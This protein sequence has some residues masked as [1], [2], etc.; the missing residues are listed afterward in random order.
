PHSTKLQ[1]FYKGPYHSKVKL[2]STVKSISESHYSGARNVINT[3]LEE[4]IYK[5]ALWVEISPTKTI[6]FS[7]ECRILTTELTD[8]NYEKL[9][10]SI[11]NTKF[12]QNCVIAELSKCSQELTVAEFIEFGSFRS[13]HRLQW[14]NL[15]SIL[16]SDS[17]SMDEESVAILITHALLQYGPVTDDPT[18]LLNRWCPE[19]HQQLLE[20]HFLDELMTRIERHLKDCECN[21]QK[22]LILITITIIVMRMFSL[23]NSTRK[24]Q[25]TN[26][27][28]KCRRLGEKWIQA[29]SKHIQNP[30]SLDSD[31]TNTLRDK[32]FI[33]GIACLQTFSIYADTSNSLE[34]SNQDVIFLLNISITVHDNMILTKK[35]TNM[36]VFMRN[37]LRSKERILVTIQ[38]LV[39]ELLEKTSYESLNE[40]CSLHWVIL[41]NKDNMKGLWKKRSKDKYDGWYDGVY[42]SNTISIDCVRGGFFVNELSIGFL[43]DKITSD[44]L[45][46]RVFGQHIFEV[47]PSESE[48]TYITKYGYHANGKTHYEFTFN[49]GNNLDGYLIV[50]ER[51]METNDKFELI[52]PSCFETELPDILVSNYS[53]WWNEK[54]QIV[55]FRSIHFLDPNFLTDKHY[56]LELKNGFIRT[57]NTKNR[58]NLINPSSQF[59]QNLFAMYFKRLDEE[60]YVYMLREGITIFHIH[61]SRLGIAFKYD[62][63]NKIITSREYSDMHIDENQLFGTLTGLESGLL[64]SSIAKVNHENKHYLCR[65]LIV[66]FGQLQSK[67][68]SDNDHQIVT[69]E[70]KSLE[71]SFI[72][73]YFV[74]TLNDRLRILQPTDSPT[75]YLYSAL[76]HALTSHP[77]PDQYTGMTG[78]ERSFQLLYSA[79]CWSDQPFDS[80][81]RNILLQIA[82]IS[83]RVN[84]YP[85]YLTSM[86]KVDWNSNSIP[87]SM[88]HFGYYLL[89]KELSEASEEWSFMYPSST[90]NDDLQKLF[91]SKKYNEKVLAKLYWDYRD[92]YN[93]SARLPEQMEKEIQFS[94]TS[95]DAYQPVWQTSSYSTTYYQ[96]SV[97]DFLYSRGDVNLKDSNKLRCTPLSRWLGY[98]YNVRNT[99]IGLFKIVEEL[100]TFE[101]DKQKDEMERFEMLLDFLHYIS[102]KG[103]RQPFYLQLLKSIL[104]APSLSLGSVPYPPFILYNKIQENSFDDDCVDLD[105]LGSYKR[106]IVLQEIRDCYHNNQHYENEKFSGLEFLNK[107]TNRINMLLD[108]WRKNAK[109]RSFLDNIESQLNSIVLVPFNAIVRVNP[110]EFSL[111][112]FQ[113]HTQI[114]LNLTH[115]TIHE[116]LLESAKQ[117]FLHPYSNY[118]IKP[119]ACIQIKNEQNIFPEEIFPSTNPQVNPLSDIAKHFKEH[120]R[121]SWKKFNLTKEYKREY[122]SVEEINEFLNSFCQESTQLWDEL[123]KS[124][125]NKNELIYKTGLM[126]RIVPTTLISVLWLNDNKSNALFLQ[127]TSEQRIL[128]GG[129]MVNWVVEQQIERTLHLA[130]QEKWEDFDKEISNIPHANWTPSEHIPW[131]ILE[132]EMNIT[133]REIQIEVARHMMQ[134]KVH[135]DNSK[136][137]NVVM[138]MN[139]GEGKTSVILPMLAVSLC[140]STSSLVRIIVLKALFPMNYQSLQ[141]KLGG[142]LNRCVLPFACRRDMNFDDSQVNKIFNRLKQG[143]NNRDVILTSPEDIL[144]FDLLTIDKCRRNEFDAGRAMLSI[145]NWTKIFVRDVLD[146]SDEILHV[147]YQLIYSIGRQQ[148]VDGGA[149]RWR[150]IQDVLKL[151]KKYSA[152]IAQKYN[153]DVFYKASESQSSFPEF[154]LLNHRPFSE[155]CQLIANDW[156]NE[157]HY[158]KIDQ[159]NILSFL[160]SI[161]SSL[162]DLINPFPHDTIQLF[163]IIRGLLSSEVLFASLKKRHRVNFGVNQNS[164]FNR[165]MAV[166]FRAKDVA[167][168]NTEFGHPDMAIVL[169]QISYYYKGL[170]DSQMFQ[171]FNRLNQHESDPEMTYNQWISLEKQND[172]I[173]S[174]KQWKR[175]NLKDY[176]Q[177][178]ELLFPTFRYNMLV[179]DYFLNHFVFPKEAKQFPNKLISSPWDLSSSSRKQIITGFSGTNDT[180]L[181]LPTHI[182]QCDLP[183]LQKT[184]AIVL[185]NLLRSENDHYHDLPIDTNSDEI[186]KRIVNDKSIV[187]VILDVGA[188]F[189]DGT[190]RQIA[191]KWLDLSDKTKIDYGVYFESDSIFVCDRQYRDHAFS[192]SPACERLDRCVFYLDEIHTRGTDFKFPNG[193]RAAVTLGNGLSKDRL[194]QACMRMRKLGKQHWLSFWSSNEA[195]QQIRTMKKHSVQSNAIEDINDRIRLMD[196]LRWVYKNTQQTTWDGLHLWATQSLSFQRKVNA[197]RRINW[198]NYETVYPNTILKNLAK[199][200]LENEVLEL[201][202]MYGVP[203]TL[204]IVVD[205]Y[206]ARY[207][208]IGVCSSVEIHEAVSKRLR[209]YSGSKKLLTQLLDEEQQRELE[210][211]QEL[212][213]E[214]QEKRPL[215]ANPY[216]PKLD[217]DIMKLCEMQGPMLNLSELTLTFFP[218]AAAFLG[219]TFYEECQPHC[220][221]QHLWITDEFKRV[222]QTCGEALD[223]FLRPPRWILI[224]RNKHVISVSPFEANWLMGELQGLYHRPSSS[225]LLTTTLRMLLPRTKPEQSIFINTETL[226]MPPSISPNRGAVAF[227]IPSEWLAELFV[228]NGTLYFKTNEEQI[229]YCRCLGVCPKPRTAAEEDAF[230]RYWIGIDV[231]LDGNFDESDKDFKKSLQQLRCV[232]ASIEMFTDAEECVKF[233]GEIQKEKVFMIAAGYLGRQVVPEIQ[234]MPQLESVYVFCGNQARHEQWAKKIPK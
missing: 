30:S 121:E 3:P 17:L 21:W 4:Y 223:S 62:A 137:Q 178:T 198:T 13:G 227:S 189:I 134:P 221:Q 45:F 52:P 210:R 200:C 35:S 27:V 216:E 90:S 2:V 108:L 28:F 81:T 165:L 133:I 51:H 32:I 173:S 116:K 179:I 149:E 102:G 127:L 93:P 8:P 92:S 226:T 22:E 80:I 19:S 59:F 91:E 164:K 49:D 41:R 225:K 160:L 78:M 109:L 195:H 204:Q 172:V 187:Q 6:E 215:P 228:F 83:P 101:A 209:D 229:A 141:H 63:Q 211:E 233:L 57:C 123:V 182:R 138:Q 146:E 26:L 118:F 105:K 135:D 103:S 68:N 147:K 181:L 89:V 88:Q 110:Q 197:F 12:V 99:W 218:I 100:K 85:E 217:N 170:N 34:L 153:D 124:I 176:Q 199:E 177:R 174:I 168:E 117:K 154:R 53:H 219:T 232:V 9:K 86:I 112:P 15:L 87:Y 201:N 161:R 65:K 67:K 139:M 203:K 129:V 185:N 188:L 106:N 140:S 48:K 98:E 205:I 54:N 145:Q 163:L 144:S 24:K 190:N 207:Q 148:Q 77:L 159:Q 39:S 202:N 42:E 60:S 119:K 18:S 1:P 20:D 114:H 58:Q 43:P 151:V 132:L 113:N 79:G 72:H 44:N 38:P 156:I 224:Y 33:I 10:F 234:S 46:A 14:W 55:E 84:Y 76:L 175:V 71:T 136:I 206:L 171:C 73:E 212:E 94:A 194:V 31:N 143:L 50:Y 130:N 104:K 122:P 152:N 125:A 222:I 40:F 56:I 47:Q 131:L 155:L 186:L 69:I 70:R 231:W 16:E 96:H 29:I 75:G 183:E 23:C 169:T 64:L 180:Q 82:S 191:I 196:I 66:P 5:S 74:F 115:R 97:A 166:P 230:E 37:L 120:L 95:L 36:S 214:R 167:A 150:T 61:L 25:M 7:E 111:E 193:F 142:L 220:W 184:D 11:D 128:L 162:E 107:Q 157:K 192:T 213:E 158:H 126:L 208:H